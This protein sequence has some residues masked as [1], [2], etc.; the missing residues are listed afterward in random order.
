ME[1]ERARRARML[2]S[3]GAFSKAATSLHTQVAELEEEQQ[4]EWAKRLLPTSSR[5]EVARAVP[6]EVMEEADNPRGYAL[7]GVHFRAMSAPGPSG[8]RPERL[9]EFVAVRDKWI[10]SR[11]LRAC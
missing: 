1:V 4:L 8:A 3:E 2:V 9:R 7:A 6:S 5:P 10:A 11:L